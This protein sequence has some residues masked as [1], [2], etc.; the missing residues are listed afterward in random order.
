VNKTQT[1]KVPVYKSVDVKLGSIFFD[2]DKHNIRADQRGVMDDISNKIKQ[3][4]RGHITIDAYTDS[5]SNAEY[6]IALAKRRANTVR[7]ELQRRLGNKLMRNVK[8]EVD[9]RATQEIPHN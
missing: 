7:A 6:N 1:R 9:P 4:G 3:Y 5:R 8:V 2:N